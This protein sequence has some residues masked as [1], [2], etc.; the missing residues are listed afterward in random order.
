M[1][2]QHQLL[3]VRMQVDLLVY[4]RCAGHRHPYCERQPTCFQNSV[5]ACVAVRPDS[6]ETFLASRVSMGLE[7][8]SS[9]GW[10]VCPVN[11]S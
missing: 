1:I 6:L 7:S 3:G 9:D 4:P 2:P 8:N 10:Q 11:T 5:I